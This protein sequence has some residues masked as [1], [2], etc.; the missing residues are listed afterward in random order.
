MVKIYVD[1]DQSFEDKDFLFAS[2][3]SSSGA[4]G[5]VGALLHWMQGPYRRKPQ[6]DSIGLLKRFGRPE[7]PEIFFAASESEMS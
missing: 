3:S 2:A 7:R 5:S 1:P 6:P 4:S